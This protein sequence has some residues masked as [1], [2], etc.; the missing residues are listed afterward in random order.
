MGPL[1]GDLSDA[2][3]IDNLAY[4]KV[5]DVK[6]RVDLYL[7]KNASSKPSMILCIH[8]GGWS[9]G[10]KKQCP[11]VM[12]VKAGYAVGKCS[13]HTTDSSRSTIGELLAAF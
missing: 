6:L 12:T 7:P 10:N 11:A 1:F 13:R 5:G 4:E 9:G 3:V 8:G 2:T